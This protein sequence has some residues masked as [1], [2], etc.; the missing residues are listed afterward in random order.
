MN[1]EEL[2]ELVLKLLPMWQYRLAKPF[3]ALLHDGINPNI[4][5]CMQLI[6]ANGEP[7]SM[8]ELSSAMHMTK[9]QMTKT[10]NRLI[11][12][13]LGLRVGDSADR[14]I[15]RISLT[16]KAH[17]YMSVF[18][19]Q[20][21]NYYN[22]LFSDMEPADRQRLAQSLTVLYE[23]FEKMPCLCA[24]KEETECSKDFHNA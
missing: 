19:A 4:Y 12:L 9:Q 18:T 1:N 10:V 7:M 8:G 16:D 20:Q 15:V 24:E 23:I 5:H 3:K 22:R 17:D 21:T 6:S 2:Q 13:E 14:R 11:E